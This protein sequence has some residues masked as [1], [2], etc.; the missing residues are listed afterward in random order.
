MSHSTKATIG[1]MSHLR[2]TQSRT[3]R[4]AMVMTNLPAASHEF[5]CF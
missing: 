1:I 5:I 4:Y 3:F 2:V